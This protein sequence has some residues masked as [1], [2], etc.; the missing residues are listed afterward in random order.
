LESAIFNG[1]TLCWVNN[2]FANWFFDSLVGPHGK[3]TTLFPN[4]ELFSWHHS[5]NRL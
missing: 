5:G 3:K 1:W 2:Q 4:W